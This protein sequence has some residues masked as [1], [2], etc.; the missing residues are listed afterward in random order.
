LEAADE[1]V[2]EVFV[3]SVVRAAV[4]AGLASL[5]DLEHE[6]EQAPR[7]HTRALRQALARARGRERVIATRRLFDGLGRLG[8]LGAMRDVAIYG[9]RRRIVVA[10]ALWP[11]RALVVTVDAKPNQ[12]AEL[13]RLGFAVIQVSAHALAEDAAEVV[14][15]IAAALAARPEATLPR[16]VAL[17]P[18]GRSESDLTAVEEVHSRVQFALATTPTLPPWPG[19]RVRRPTFS[20][21]F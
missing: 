20:G 3:E 2:A 15:G 17:L 1:V 8:P 11:T 14:S 10:E 5:S 6:L 13:S 18:L 12:V 7:R 4:S 9:E 21:A 16:G 19:L